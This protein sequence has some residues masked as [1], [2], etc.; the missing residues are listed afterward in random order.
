MIFRKKSAS[1]EMSFRPNNTGRYVDSSLSEEEINLSDN[2]LGSL[3]KYKFGV[4]KEQYRRVK[5]TASSCQQALIE[6]AAL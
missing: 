4:G 2:H 6:G 5:G 1:Q 3:R